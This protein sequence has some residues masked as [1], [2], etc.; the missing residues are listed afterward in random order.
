MAQP[1]MVQAEVSIRNMNQSE[2]REAMANQVEIRRGEV[3]SIT[4]TIPLLSDQN[5]YLVVRLPE[6]SVR[7]LMDHV[8]T[9]PEGERNAFI[10][11]WVMRNQAAVLEQYINSG[12]SSRHFRYDV[13]PVRVEQAQEPASREAQPASPVAS[14]VPSRREQPSPQ[15]PVLEAEPL[16]IRR[17]TTQE[18]VPSQNPPVQAPAEQAIVSPPPEQRQREYAFRLSGSG[19]GTQEEPYVIEVQGEPARGSDAV[20]IPMHF[21]SGEIDI[22]VKIYLR[23]SDLS[24]DS[25]ARTTSDLKVVCGQAL[26]QAGFSGD[27]IAQSGVLNQIG[28]ALRSTRRAIGD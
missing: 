26:G 24:D 20:A 1:S 2:A 23:R 15:P 19:S 3:R 18:A 10:K 14:A 21:Q 28:S 17:T 11:E 7:S 25:I 12:Q 27:A 4:L 8:A 9:L 16:I 22:H 5:S 13:V 6:E